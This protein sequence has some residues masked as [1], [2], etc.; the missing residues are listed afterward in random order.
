MSIGPS[1]AAGGPR[2]LPRAERFVR[3]ALLAEPA[4]LDLHREGFFL[5]LAGKL[6][7]DGQFNISLPDRD[8]LHSNSLTGKQGAGPSSMRGGGW[9]PSLGPSPQRPSGSL[10]AILVAL[11]D[12][13]GFSNISLPDRGPSPAQ[14]PPENRAEDAADR[15]G[16]NWCLVFRDGSDLIPKQDF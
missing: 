10:F 12:D 13:G 4:F 7:R 5:S 16:R 6:C 2:W 9:S 11:V 3:H 8:F 1:Y 15:P 14:S